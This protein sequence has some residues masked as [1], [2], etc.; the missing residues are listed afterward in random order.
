MFEFGIGRMFAYNTDGSSVEFGTLQSA[1]IK[2]NFSK[3]ELYGRNQMPVKV[4]RGKGTVEGDAESARINAASLNQILDGTKTTGMK[5][6]I[7][8]AVNAT[9]PATTPFTLTV[10]TIPGS[11]T[12]GK[13]L[14]VYN[15]TDPTIAVPMTLVGSAPATGQFSFDAATKTFTFAEAD[16]SKKVQYIYDYTVT[17]G[18]TITLTNNAM[19]TSPVF[20]TQLYTTLDGKQIMLALNACTTTSLDLSMKQEDFLIP[21]FNFSAFAD[22]SDVIGYL[23]IEE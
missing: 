14:A 1:G 23:Y 20:Q 15:V 16:A 4:V 21:K 8:P 12:F 2:F 9:I 18:S 10:G 19:G 11:G 17:T 3:K 7:D 5:K 13:L 22:S 6:I